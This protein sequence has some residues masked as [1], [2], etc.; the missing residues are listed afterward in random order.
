M[1][2]ALRGWLPGAQDLLMFERILFAF[3]LGGVLGLERETR[4][5]W[6]G[7]HTHM[8]VTVGSAAFT[9][10]SIYG[11]GGGEGADTSRVAAQIVSGVGFLGAGAIFRAGAQLRGLT[12]A[13]TIWLAAAVGMLVGA[14]LYWPAGFLAAMT[15]LALRVLRLRFGPKPG[16]EGYEEDSE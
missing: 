14:G 12:T 10:A 13:A 16:E 11:F 5:K 9:L 1:D 4:R 7:L 6:A 2:E 8:L 15:V 3:L